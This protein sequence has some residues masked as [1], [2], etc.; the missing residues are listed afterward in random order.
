ME[1][2]EIQ[3]KIKMKQSLAVILALVMV[4][5]LS[6]CGGKN[7]GPEEVGSYQLYEMTFEGDVFDH[8][9]L[10]TSG[11]AL[12]TM[13]LAADG[14]G[15]IKIDGKATITWGDGKITVNESNAVYTYTYKDGMIVLEESTGESMTFKKTDSAD[16]S[17]GLKQ[18]GEIRFKLNSSKVD[19]DEET[20]LDS[21]TAMP[22][23]R[24][25]VSRPT[26]GAARPGAVR[27]G[28]VPPGGRPMPGRAPMGGGMM[29]GARV[30]NADEVRASLEYQQYEQMGQ[31]I[32]E[33]LLQVRQEARD[34]AAAANA[35][36]TAVTCPYC[37]ATT[38]PDASGCCEFC[39]GAI[40]G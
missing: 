6:A 18:V 16:A 13:E 32:R 24:S 29:G 14:T 5:S 39:G 7:S 27:P 37:G 23:S 22:R 34:T 36:K 4:L 11:F 30:S 12:Y 25:G 26:P 1:K 31:E 2:E 15:W 10:E 40:G 28:A 21:P 20:L 33:A 35:P 38:T 3:V 8:D 19:N 9:F 17:S